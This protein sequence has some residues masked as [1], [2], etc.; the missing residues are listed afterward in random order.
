MKQKVL[1]VQAIHERG[2]QVFGDQADVRV[3]SDPSVETVIREIKGVAGVVVRTAPFPRE[4]M[5]AADTLKVIGRHGVGVDNIDV[6]AATEKGIVVVNTPLANATSVAEHTILV[7][8]ALA[9][10]MLFMDKATREGRW[11]VRNEY[12]T[13]DLDGKVLGLIGLGRVGTMVAKKAMAAYDM[14]VM[15]YD[16]YVQPDLARS[17]GVAL[18]QDVD[19]IFRRADVVSLHTPFTPQTRG[20]VSA[21]RLRLMK[22]TAFLINTARGE[23]VDETALYEALKGGAVAGA[24]LDVYAEEP[25]G[26][27]NPLFSLDQVILSPHSA[28]LTQECVIRM[29]T[30][31]AEGVMDVLRGKRPQFVVNPEVL[32]KISLS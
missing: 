1:I 17:L 5:E 7:I 18:H 14:T 4:I 30:G 2:V 16:P 13:V 27:D 26:K 6:K 21:D 31:A 32:K 23:V 12:R 28:A 8:G 9:K 11:E 3:A 10:R 22:P 20:L 29:A 19:E 25:P 15:A 24:A